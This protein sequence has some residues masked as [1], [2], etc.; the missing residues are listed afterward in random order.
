MTETDMLSRARAIRARVE[1]MT[2]DELNA[3]YLEHVGYKPSE[4]DP[5]LSP[6]GLC[7]MIAGSMFYRALPD[8]VDTEGAE[9]MERRLTASIELGSVI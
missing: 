3:W 9:A 5:S 6:T 4:D 7:S 1:D 2:Y 8:G